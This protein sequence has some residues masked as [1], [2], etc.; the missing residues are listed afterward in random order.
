LNLSKE[1]RLQQW[2]IPADPEKGIARISL[3]AKLKAVND[4]FER[5][6]KDFDP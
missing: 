4:V 2:T 5:S 1:P 3:K 6:T